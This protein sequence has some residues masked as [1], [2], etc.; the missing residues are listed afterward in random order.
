MNS[1]MIE[2]ARELAQWNA[3][4]EAF[5]VYQALMTPTDTPSKKDFLC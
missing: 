5:S 3:E 1:S 4:S 2:E